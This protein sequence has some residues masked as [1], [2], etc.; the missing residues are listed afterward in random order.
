MAVDFAEL[1]ALLSGVGLALTG[2]ALQD[3]AMPAGALVLAT[4]QSLAPRLSGD[5]INHLEVQASHSERAATVVVQVADSAPGGSV[6]Q[7]IFSEFGTAHEQARP[8]MRPAFEINKQ[9]A[10][11]LILNKIKNQL[12]A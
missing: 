10:A 5:L 2:Q 12:K 1:D 3:A 4:A 7:A 9:A 8:F 11:D 6:R